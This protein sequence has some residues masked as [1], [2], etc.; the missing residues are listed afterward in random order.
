MHSSKEG[1]YELIPIFDGCE[2]LRYTRLVTSD[3]H[4]RANRVKITQLLYRRKNGRFQ[5]YVWQY[6]QPT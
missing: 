2:D 4:S 5:T 3:H 1:F 6:V